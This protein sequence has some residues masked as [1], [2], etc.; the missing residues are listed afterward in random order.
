VCPRAACRYLIHVGWDA[1][2]AAAVQRSID[3]L[4]AEEDGFATAEGQAA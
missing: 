2:D 3:G 1:D 4:R